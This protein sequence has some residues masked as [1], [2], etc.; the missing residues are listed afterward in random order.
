MN[1]TKKKTANW[2]VKF[3]LVIVDDDDD[4]VNEI[5]VSGLELDGGATFGYRLHSW[6]ENQNLKS[7]RL[8]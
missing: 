3:L 4:G 2:K 7:Q 1:V 5:V 6:Q 8:K